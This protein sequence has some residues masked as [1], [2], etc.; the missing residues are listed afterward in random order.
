MTPPGGPAIVAENASKVFLDGTVLAFHQLSL[1][2]R[3]QEILCI[4]GPSGCGKTTLLR[5]IAGLTDLSGGKLLVDGG[6]VNNTP[7]SHA[8][9]LGAERI[10]VLPTNDLQT[11]GREVRPQGALDA[12]V[13]AFTLLVGARLEADLARYAQEAELIVLPATNPGRVQPT[14]FDHSE[15]L[16]GSALRAAKGALDAVSQPLAA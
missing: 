13:H 8:V 1:A 5:C 2:V 15:H 11:R 14:D 16:I 4:V 10:Y 6:V 7:I 3:R 12:A 9:N